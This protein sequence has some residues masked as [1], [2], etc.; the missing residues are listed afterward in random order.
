MTK[1]IKPM[2]DFWKQMFDELNNTTSEEWRIY[3][4]HRNQ[5]P[6]CSRCRTQK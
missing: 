4:G 2:D 5:Q 6:R 3:N 1:P